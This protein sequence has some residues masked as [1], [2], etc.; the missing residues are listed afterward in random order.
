LSKGRVITAA[1][2]PAW[3]AVGLLSLALRTA[4]AA[5]P[6]AGSLA[7][8]SLEELSNIQITSVSKR[9]E[10][11]SDAAAS[12]FVITADDI[13][14]AGVRRLPDAL[15][16][17]PNLEVA[18]I[19]A[20]AYAISA[21]GFNGAGA[22][23]N[24][25]LVL[26]DGRS[27][28]TPLYAGVFWDSQDVMLEDVERIEVISG[29]GGTLWGVNA[30]NG[31]INIITRSAA[32]TQ[33][34]LVPAG[35]GSR[36]GDAAFRYGGAFGSDG[37]YRVY[38]MYFD[39]YHTMTEP[40]ATQNDAWHKSQGGFRI[41]WSRAGESLTVNGNGYF[42]AEGQPLSGSGSLNGVPLP[43]GN[44][45]I[46][47]A[48]L[49]G[50]WDQAL[51]GGSSLSLQGYYDRTDRD[52]PPTFS[53]SLDIFDVQLQHSLRPIGI[54]AVAWGGEFRYAMDRVT[55]ATFLAFTPPRPFFGFLP[56]D[57]NQRWPSLFAQDEVMLRANLRLTVGARLER[58]DYTGTEFLPNI[59]LAWKIAPEHLLWTAA[60]R[61]VRAPSRLDR[62]TYIP[63]APPFLLAGGPDFRSEVANVYEI[64]YRGQLTSRL[65][66]SVTLYHT[67]YDHLRTAEIAP[68]RAFIIL[69]NQM[70]GHSTGIETWGTYQAAETWR[71]S[72]GLNAL[73]ERLTLR[74]GSTDTADVIAQQ[75]RDP[76]HTW[77]LRSSFDF[78]YRTEFDAIV[79]RVS[80]LSDP[81]VPGY[82]AIDLRA[83][84]RARRDLELSLTG[85]NLFSGGH[86]EF[87][88]PAT[89]TRFGQGVFFKVA[90]RV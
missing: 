18:Q 20:S 47:G 15:R 26:I 76:T 25:L 5:G 9:A 70:Q 29:P 52:D 65:S 19:N 78:A 10:R 21:R 62:D 48:N 53:E 84:W 67:D 8:L 3:I 55:N 2:R 73:R 14:R 41:D 45:S 88:D 39:Q 82:T 81:A 57:V 66:Y 38:G 43:R 16:L 89:R 77:M 58:N 49:T 37:Q 56:A 69:S 22:G 23:S 50:R 34:G 35:I 44:I 75:G 1:Q 51:E 79:R 42:A 72:A 71:L 60:S 80:A 85:E 46:S 6:D 61:A 32:S 33:G 31:V 40:G 86:G 64:G 68:S 90:C 63:A 30:V 13:R 4:V 27:V 7:D 28:Y 59:R 17:A 87:T 83:G 36:D 54:H 11:L 12:L 24:K 74:P